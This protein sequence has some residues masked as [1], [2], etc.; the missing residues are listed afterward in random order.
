MTG[1]GLAITG[2]LLVMSSPAV[3]RMADRE[4]DVRIRL[5]DSDRVGGMSL[6]VARAVAGRI[7][8]ST[9]ARFRWDE[10]KSSGGSANTIE[11][12]FLDFAPKNQPA[13][14]LA[15]AFPFAEGGMRIAVFLDRISDLAN[16]QPLFMPRILGHVL[17]HEIGHVLRGTNAHSWTGVMKAHWDA[18]DYAAMRKSSLPFSAEDVET[19]RL[20]LRAR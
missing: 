15:E 6:P 11:I 20:R 13:G 14:A 7:L 18:S 19:I 5:I 1:S 4:G 9:G 16:R 3:A 10:G 8:S 2:F 17:A 12:R